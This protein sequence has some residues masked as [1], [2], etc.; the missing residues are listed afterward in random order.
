LY[1]SYG[2]LNVILP[3][4]L[5]VGTKPTIQVVSNQTT[6]NQLSDWTVEKAGISLFRV[7][8]A[9][10][11]LNQDG[12]PNSPQNPAQPG[13][14]V[15]LFGTGGGQTVPPSV[16]G[17][18]TPPGLRPLVSTPQVQIVDGPILSV[19]Y[20]GAAPGLVSGVTQINIKLP[21]VIPVVT[22]YPKGTLP[23]DMGGDAIDFYSGNVTISVAVH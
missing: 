9:A 22:G 16:A 21:D 5:V 11:A 17:Q 13:S 8:N 3:Y 14:V 18:V 15:T 20:A 12:T 6:A 2:Q 4:S 7:G 19:K 10:V 1:S 23:L